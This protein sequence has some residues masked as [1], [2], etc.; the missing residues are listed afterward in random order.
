MGGRR[1]SI[2][3]AA[4][5]WAALGDGARADDDDNKP[6]PGDPYYRL[7]T[8]NLFGALEGAD[9]GEAG[10]RSVELETTAGLFKRMGRYAFIEQ[11]VIYEFTP[12]P[13]LG[14]EIGAHAF[15]QAIHGT[16]G[17]YSGVDLSGL[18]NEWRYV[19]VP[20]GG[21][22]STQLTTTLTPQVAR[23]FE[24][25]AH[26]LDYALPVLF[27]LDMQ[28]IERRLYAALNVSYAPEIAVPQGDQ[29]SR[30][31]TLNASGAL[32]WRLTPDA[33]LGIEADALNAFDGLAAQSWRGSAFF[34]GPTF[35]YQFNDKVDLSG[36][37]TQQI[38]GR[39]RSDGRALD[40]TNF[41]RSQAKLRLEI[42]F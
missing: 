16:V 10:D 35:H 13:R 32:S 4:A 20:R 27:I 22:W 3:A 19:L 34:L 40:L 29:V 24:G 36:G 23:V 42:D 39:A 1:S 17:N 7:D 33:M 38:A 11:E 2:W 8:K 5:L 25:G 30:L 26:G 12:T 31:S 9:V 15:G 37:W 21:A 18:S 28:P 14:I 6:K 41:S